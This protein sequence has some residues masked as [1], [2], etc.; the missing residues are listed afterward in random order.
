MA[1]YLRIKELAE[2]RGWNITTLA[3][4]AQISYPTALALWHDRAFQ[5]S[6]TTLDRIAAALG[7]QVADLFGGTP[8]PLHEQQEE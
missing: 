1:T 4:K 2:Q 3:R 6:K 8:E 5:Y 7:C